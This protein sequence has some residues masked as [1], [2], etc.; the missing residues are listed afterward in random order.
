M[1]LKSSEADP[2]ATGDRAAVGFGGAQYAV[3]VGNEKIEVGC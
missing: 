1:H 3:G 2:C